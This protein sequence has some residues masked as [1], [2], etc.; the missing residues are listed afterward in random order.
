M[1]NIIL[2]GL[3]LVVAVIVEMIWPVFSLLGQAKPPMVMG[4]VLYYALHRPLALMVGAAMFGGIMND[5]MNA[6]PLGFSSLALVL[7]G[8]L[9]RFYRNVVFSRRWITHMVFGTLGSIGMTLVLYGL[10]CL[11]DSGGREMPVIWVALKVVGVAAYGLVLVPLVF[12]V[13]E[14]LDHTVGNMEMAMSE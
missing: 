8:L 3:A 9:A 2:M 1:M 13:M 5:S 4:V 14:R 10:L 11:T 7:V 12:R 6:L